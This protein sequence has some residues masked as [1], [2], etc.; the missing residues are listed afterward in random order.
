MLAKL[1]V[2]HSRLQPLLH[3]LI[4]RENK[5]MAQMKYIIGELVCYPK[6]F[7]HLLNIK[8]NLGVETECERL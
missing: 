5:A 4:T 2:Y 1:S 7:D 3:I 8:K 6:S